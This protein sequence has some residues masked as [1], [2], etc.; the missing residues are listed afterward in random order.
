MLFFITSEVL[1]NNAAVTDK[2]YNF[3]SFTL[4]FFWDFIKSYNMQI[5]MNAI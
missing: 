2:K 3:T 1:V 4:F 5:K